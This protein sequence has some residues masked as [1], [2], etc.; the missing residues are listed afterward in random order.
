METTSSLD[1]DTLAWLT[2][3]SIDVISR[4]ERSWNHVL[5]VR[6]TGA[7]RVGLAIYKPRAGEYPLW[8]FPH[9]TLCLRERAAY[10]VSVFLGW[11]RIPPTVLRDGPYGFGA[12]QQFVEADPEAN[13]F[14]LRGSRLADL[15]PVALFDH[16]INN[17]D[18]KG[19]HIL[20]DREGRLWA[21]DH[22]L[23]F[24][25]EPKLR[26][27]IWDFAGEPIPEPY[28]DD[29]R[30]LRRELT[31]EVPADGPSIA[32][33]LDRLLEPGEMRALLRRLDALL[34]TSR[35]PY[36]DPDRVHLPWPLI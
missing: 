22:A 36:P 6:V 27:V 11:P 3:G 8:D 13:Y 29:L 28:L 25:E 31:A 20:L 24:N 2:T 14:T 33:A 10:L 15:L 16:L 34:E 9:G 5:L 12:L 19:G 1:N 23:T 7:G 35:F 4:V 26:T 21:I 17:A 32:R 18:R 30:R